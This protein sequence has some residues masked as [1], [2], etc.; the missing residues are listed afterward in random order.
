MYLSNILKWKR[1]TDPKRDEAECI[2][3]EVDIFKG[4]SF[5]VGCIHRPPDL[6]VS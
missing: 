5:F 4:S 1:Q 6:L 3:V 2:W